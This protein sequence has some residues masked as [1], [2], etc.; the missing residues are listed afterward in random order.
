VAGAPEPAAAWTGWT[1]ADWV[2]LL[3]RLTDGFT[4]AVPPGGSPAAAD[5]PGDAGPGRVPAIE[6]FARMSVAWAAWL[7]EPSNGRVLEHG[8]RRHDV[9]ALL[10]RGLVDATD[11]RHPAWWGT[12]GDRDQRIVEAAEVATAL[13]LG[14]ERLRASLAALDP[15]APDRLLDWLA[16]VDGR[17]LWPDNWVL[18]PMVVALARRALGRPVPDAAIDDAIAWMLG[19]HVGDGWS[20]DG[21]GHALDLYT[22]WA[23]HWHLLWW[24]RFDG[25]RRPARR[26]IVVRRA[27]AWL[28]GVEPLVAADG[29]YP[30]FGRSLGYRFAFAAPFA[31]A[32]LLGIDPLVPGATRRLASGVV[33]RAVD[34]GAI[35]PDTDWFRVGVGGQRPAVVE[36]YVT[37]GAVAW[38]AHAF[39]ALA[40][41][42]AH[43]FWAAPEAPL[44][45]DRGTA[46]SLAAG[47]AGLLAT[48][49]AGGETRLHNAR[50]GH[51][52]DIADH[53]YAATYGKVAYRSAFPCDVPIGTAASAGSDDA[54]AAIEP[55]RVGARQR[56]VH[57]TETDAG[58]AGPGWVIARYGLAA[59]GGRVAVTTAVLVL[60][61]AEVR[62]S[63]IGN[64]AAAVRIRD[65]GPILDGGVDPAM[66]LSPVEG[67]A[68]LVLRSTAGGLVGIRALL[69]GTVAR[70]ID[71]TPDRPNLVHAPAPHLAAEEVAPNAH[72]RLLA[73][74]H[75]AVAAVRSGVTDD[76]T[77]VAGLLEAIEVEPL[78]P[79]A[80]RLRAPGVIATVDLA[81]RPPDRLTM[82]GRE[83]HGPGLRLVR[84]APDG[85]SFAGERVAGVDG[86]FALE[87][88]GIA[89]VARRAAGVEAT[90]AA[91]IRIDRGW[92]GRPVSHLAVRRGAGPFEP[93]GTLD[94]PG[95][96]P[97]RVIRR[98]A[99]AHGTHLVGLRLSEGP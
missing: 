79:T 64:S 4:R 5:L 71:P 42:A 61:D 19:H 44:P 49:T 2:G 12:I 36:G 47:R 21:P 58:S 8:G 62:V 96:V 46:G 74:A 89:A 41:P 69:G 76:A 6:G 40:M 38:A 88:P 26:A 22:G 18:F 20:S 87:R 13:L 95:V 83:V 30:R 25:G 86:V 98:L 14:G 90:V 63:L 3:A 32:A 70:R 10:A 68:C 54:V 16:Q 84:A 52:A 39:V 65:G 31:Q 17:D 33:R 48:W 92:A 9:G 34:D 99:R 53:D 75:V 29:A 94:E 82:A 27:R 11:P 78:G 72:A 57:R 7:H 55:S 56:I 23:I 24:V 50:S 97:D 67:R 43:P 77:R 66:A 45:A 73:T 59:D 28:A 15:A 85:S 37:P 93:I 1:R 80:V 51:P 81:A 60:D 91:G 35:D